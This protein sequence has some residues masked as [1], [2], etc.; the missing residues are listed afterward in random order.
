MGLRNKLDLHKFHATKK[1]IIAFFKY[2]M[3]VVLERKIA[4]I[5]DQVFI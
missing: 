5:Y 1:H 2:I 4:V 3:Q